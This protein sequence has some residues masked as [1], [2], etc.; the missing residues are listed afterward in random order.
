MNEREKTNEHLHE[1]LSAYL[2]GELDA[3]A[4]ARLE[5]AVQADA[6]LAAELTRLRATRKLVRG[7]ARAEAPNGFADDVLAQAERQQLIRAGTHEPEARSM[8]WVRL[9]ATA[10]MLLIVCGAGVTIVVSLRQATVGRHPAES[11]KDADKLAQA[12]DEAE[13]G[14]TVEN[15]SATPKPAPEAGPAEKPIARRHSE[16]SPDVENVVIYTDDLHVARREVE[17][18]LACNSIQPL[19]PGAT[20]L[21]YKMAYAYEVEEINPTQV[22]YRVSASAK[23]MSRLNSDLNLIRSRQRVS[24]LQP[25]PKLADSAGAG[26]VVA[27]GKVFV[28]GTTVAESPLVPE[29]KQAADA[30]QAKKSY[31]GAGE[32]AS[33]NDKPMLKGAGP[34]KL[35]SRKRMRR[36]VVASAVTQPASRPAT[37]RVRPILITLNLRKYEPATSRPARAGPTT[38]TTTQTTKPTSRPSED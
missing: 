21:S 17:L 7:L 8:R 20:H 4:A 38:Q 26:G 10:A 29:K 37:A 6:E 14:G 33:L 28:A 30:L 5:Q 16:E 19:T 25:S 18:V 11:G 36:F 22:K 13:R 1:Q 35:E 23:Q 2:D 12:P 24:Q 34:S 32:A 9:L 31:R 15:L 3:R 27:A